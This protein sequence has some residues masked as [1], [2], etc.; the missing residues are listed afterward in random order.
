MS[1]RDFQIIRLL[2]RLQDPIYYADNKWLIFVSEQLY[3]WIMQYPED[4][5]RF[6]T[7]YLKWPEGW[8]LIRK[9]SDSTLQSLEIIKNKLNEIKEINNKIGGYL[10]DKYTERG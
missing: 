4:S 6:F 8:E 1:K 10:G 5:Y 3:N 9:N 2:F 7:T